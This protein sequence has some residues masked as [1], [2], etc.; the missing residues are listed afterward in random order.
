VPPFSHPAS[1]SV[2]SS[3]L[4]WVVVGNCFQRKG[5]SIGTSSEKTPGDKCNK[6]NTGA[7]NSQIPF[8]LGKIERRK[9]KGRP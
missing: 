8:I 3:D 4:L 6:T 1:T 9:V 5:V 2:C 7:K